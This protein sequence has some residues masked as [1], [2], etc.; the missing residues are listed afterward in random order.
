MEFDKKMISLCSN[1]EIFAERPS[2]LYLHNER[3][4]LI[5]SR[6]EFVFAFNFSPLYSY[7]ELKIEVPAGNYKVVLDTDSKEFGGFERNNSLVE[8]PTLYENGRNLLP[9]YL[10]S[11]SA[12]LLKK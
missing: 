1:G 12:L 8:H 10:P 5:F 11:R 6:G 7:P 2:I 3:E 9:L 4:I